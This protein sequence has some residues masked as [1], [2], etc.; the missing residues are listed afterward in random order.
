[1]ECLV[2]T[3]LRP[4]MLR[5]ESYC[6]PLPPSCKQTHMHVPGPQA[7]DVFTGVFCLQVPCASLLLRLH[8]AARDERGAVL[9]T[10]SIPSHLWKQVGLVVKAPLY[11]AGLHFGA[12][13]E[14]TQA[15]C[16]LYAELLHR[17]VVPVREGLKAVGDGREKRL[18]SDKSLQHWIRSRLT[19]QAGVH[20][21]DMD[22]RYLCKYE[23][24]T[25]FTLKV[26]WAHHLTKARPS[27]CIVSLCPPASL[28]NG[29]LDGTV[30]HTVGWDRDERWASPLPEAPHTPSF[31]CTHSRAPACHVCTSPRTNARSA[32]HALELHKSAKA[33]FGCIRVFS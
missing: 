20:T 25:G 14:P 3:C 16:R 11:A 18:K 33:R 7:T 4:S 22:L 6:P 10:N 13:C 2:W 15:E 32:L 17:A 21:P 28:Y 29:V 9:S 12:Q 8:R 1:M 27:H 24:T 23:Q 31:L 26:L 5:S 30:Q 19:R